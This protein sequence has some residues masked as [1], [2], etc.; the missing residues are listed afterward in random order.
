MSYADLYFGASRTG[1]TTQIGVAAKRAFKKHNLPSRLVTADLG[2]LDCIQP[3]IDAGTIKVW[4]LKHHNNLIETL[5]RACQGYW[6]TDPDDP[7]TKLESPFIIQYI[8]KCPK[9]TEDSN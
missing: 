8:G 7:A 1:K 5:D 2:T 9:C 3:E 4:N 6:P